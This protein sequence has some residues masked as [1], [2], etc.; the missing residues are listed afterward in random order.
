MMLWVID[1]VVGWLTEGGLY[2]GLYMWLLPLSLGGVVLGLSF[3]VYMNF[4]LAYW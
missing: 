3:H 1:C 2:D 4:L